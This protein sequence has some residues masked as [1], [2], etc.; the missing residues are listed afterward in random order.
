MLPC[1]A[2]AL[3]ERIV[4][5]KEDLGRF[6]VRVIGPVDAEPEEQNGCRDDE[7]A[8]GRR[9]GQHRLRDPTEYTP[10]RAED[11]PERLERPPTSAPLPVARSGIASMRHGG[12][13][14]T[15]PDGGE[16]VGAFATVEF[17][18]GG[19]Y[20]SRH[21]ETCRNPS[22]PLRPPDRSRFALFC[23]AQ[24]PPDCAAAG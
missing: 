6:V 23:A 20:T 16:A 17:Q 12:Q 22:S 14:L 21:H 8:Q 4:Q 24:C 9:R 1:L 13:A 2:R 3:V 10:T 11:T 19:H 7:G 5:W 18:N 15:I